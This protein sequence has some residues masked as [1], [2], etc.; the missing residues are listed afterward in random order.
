MKTLLCILIL[1]FV[2]CSCSSNKTIGEKTYETYGLL[3]ADDNKNS[4]I[5]YKPCWGNI[6]WG[7]FL[8]ETIVASIYFFGFDY[9]EPV[10]PNNDE[11][12]VIAP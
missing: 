5:K 3:N 1:S 7:A 6:F 8:F 11:P 2:V 12:G 10:G 9:M 4:N